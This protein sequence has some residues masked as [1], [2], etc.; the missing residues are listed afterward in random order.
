MGFALRFSFKL[1]GASIAALMH[2]FLPP[3]FEKT[4]SNAVASLH[5]R[6]TSRFNQ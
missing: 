4:D 2:A 5:T 1:F 3:L 6:L